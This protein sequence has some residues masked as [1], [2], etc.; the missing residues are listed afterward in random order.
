[1]GELLR[2]YWH[3][4]AASSQLLLKP[5]LPIRL[6]G[7][8]LTLF[9]D[10]RGRIGL[11]G[12]RCAHRLIALQFGYP[13][14]EGLRC[15]YHGWTY[16]SQGQCVA[17]PAEA[18]ASTFKDKVK[19]R[20][21]PVQE[22]AG[23]IFA[24]IGPQPVPL[25]PRWEPLVREDLA[26]QIVFTEVPC[27]WLQEMENSP[28]QTHGEWLHGHFAEYALRFR[29]YAPDS[30]E[31]RQTLRFQQ[32]VLEFAVDPFE[33]GLVRRRLRQGKTKDDDTWRIGQP[34]IFPSISVLSDAGSITMIWRTPLDDTSCV[35]WDLECKPVDGPGPELRGIVP[36]TEIPMRDESGDWNLAAV[37][38]QDHVAIAAQG[39]LVDR[40]REHLGESD[41]GIIAYRQLLRQQL[42][43]IER[44]DEPLAVF[45]DPAK[46]LCIPLP[47]IGTPKFVA[48]AH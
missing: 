39:P 40:T 6:L 32:H 23:L 21:F 16:D 24:Y 44:G 30:P 33:Y 5:V 31:Y 2:R 34:M 18:G 35:Q 4:I 12:E 3:P 48:S 22:L 15:P 47:V 36:C 13:V 1:M 26:R 42:D 25:L 29:G 14:D 8:K 46:N 28:D 38:G 43:V 9:R 11:V 7:E 17:Q 19:I 41:K 37:R 45:R 10:S 27:N 20:A